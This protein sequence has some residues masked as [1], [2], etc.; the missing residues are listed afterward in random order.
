M[1][2]P[3]GIQH[4]LEPN[5]RH[6]IS[7]RPDI[8]GL[9]AIAVC[10]VILFHAWPKWVRGG[11]IGVDIFFVISGFLITSIILQDLN[12]GS[13]SIREF[14]IRRIK[15]IFPAL[16]A[17]VFATLAFGWYVLLGHEFAQLGKHITAAA[18]FLSNL[19]LWNESGYFDNDQTTKPLLHLWSLGVEEQFYLVWPLMLALTYRIRS[20]TL[21]FLSITLAASFLYGLHATFSEPVAAYFSPVSRF[22][23]LSSG[24]IVAYLMSTRNLAIPGRALVSILGVVLLALGAILIDSQRPFPGTWALLPVLGTCALIIAGNGSWINKRLLGNPL[25]VQVGLISYP[26]YLWHWP[27]ISYAYI[28][29]GEKPSAQAKAVLVLVSFVLAFLT[30][31]LIEKPVQRAANRGRAIKILVS[32]MA[33]FGIVGAFVNAGMIRE[34]IPTNGTDLYLSALNDL[35]FPQP[36]MKP[37]RYQSSLFQQLSGNGAGTTVLLGDS[38]MEQ[39]APLVA[40]GLGDSRFDRK[41]VIFATAGGCPPIPDAVKLPQ[42]RFP[43]CTQTVHDGYALAA[44][45]QVDTVVIAAAWYG[46]F[47]PSQDGVEMP[48]DG[49]LEQFP[50][51]RAHEAAYAALLR[52]IQELRAKGKRVFLILQPP[53]GDLFDPRSMIT[54]SRFGEMKPRTGMEPFRVDEFRQNNSEPRTRLMDIARATGAIVVDPVDYICKNNICPVVNATGKPIYTDPVH[55]RPYFVRSAVHYLDEALSSPQRRKIDTSKMTMR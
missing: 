51:N 16:V 30:Y 11:F 27:L 24:G 17:V 4:V 3:R 33:C 47:T 31:R 23:E 49:T 12:L 43:H 10:L 45:P 44:S 19:V 54:G 55:M 28:V 2:Y 39:Y 48:V 42:I 50:S 20:G 9:R 36:A 6:R 13:F 18:T 26:L 29:L 32:A 37:L 25:M 35:G 41:S 46:Y 1:N 21:L 14:Y 7:Y 15:R 22:W 8:D 40:Q 34:R 52:G 38:V 5:T 53:T